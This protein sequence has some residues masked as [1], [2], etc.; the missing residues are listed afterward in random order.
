MLKSAFVNT[1]LI[2]VAALGILAFTLTDV[3][4]GADDGDLH[5]SGAGASPDSVAFANAFVKRNP[6][7]GQP[8]H[9]HDLPDGAPLP[10]ATNMPATN[11]L[12]L[13]GTS[14]LPQT[15]NLGNNTIGAPAATGPVNPAH[16]Q[17]GHR[18]DIAVGAPLNG[19]A[20]LTSTTPPA[21]PAPTSKA[22]NPAHGQPGHRCDI[23]VGAPLNSAPAKAATSPTPTTSAVTTST[24]SSTAKG[25]NPPHGQPGHRC[26]IA[27]GAPLTSATP[28]T[29][30]PIVDPSKLYPF[31]TTTT[32]AANQTVTD[33]VK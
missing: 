12:S 27:V 5:L 6:P 18:C 4:S 30:A 24:T 8:G 20:P 16:G 13:T 31:P 21:A 28:A 9:R 22:L 25:L 17:P 19:A 33:S 1:A 11:N 23:A 32:T 2:V 3:F 7:H 26:D 29:S 15:I 10:Q 14:P